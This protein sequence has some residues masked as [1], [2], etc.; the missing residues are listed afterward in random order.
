MFYT[1]TVWL[2]A[3]GYTSITLVRTASG[4]IGPILSDMQALTNADWSL[5]WEGPLSTQ[6]PST[7]AAVYEAGMQRARLVFGAADGTEVDIIIPAPQI[8]IFLADGITV[9]SSN[10][11]VAQLI[12]DVIANG[13]SASGSAVTAYL[14][15]Y[16]E[17]TRG[18]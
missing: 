3:R 15:G 13:V 1:S 16:M 7:T 2:D 8:G 6:V 5:C 4:G 11:N 10:A 12:T 17:P 18:G 14:S 9:D